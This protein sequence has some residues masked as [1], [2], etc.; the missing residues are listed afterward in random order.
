MTTSDT[1]EKTPDQWRDILKNTDFRAMFGTLIKLVTWWLGLGTIILAA[2][3]RLQTRRD[4][5]A[6]A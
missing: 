2:R 4:A 1:P 3:S 5:P 6:V